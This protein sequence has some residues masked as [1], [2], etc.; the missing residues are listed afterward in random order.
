MILLFQLLTAISVFRYGFFFR[1]GGCPPFSG[2]CQFGMNGNLKI[3][4]F[5][6]FVA[7]NMKMLWHDDCEI[8]N[9]WL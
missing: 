9:F 3:T 7:K 8:L 2:E 4:I 1:R 6:S 5:N